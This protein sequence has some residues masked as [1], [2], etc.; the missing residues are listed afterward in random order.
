MIEQCYCAT[1]CPI[2]AAVEE[3]L[4]SYHQIHVE[5]LWGTLAMLQF[6]LYALTST[7][8][9]TGNYFNRN[10]NPDQLSL[11]TESGGHGEQSGP[12][13]RSVADLGRECLLR[14]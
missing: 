11:T 1:G 10:S 8:K 4:L 2:R 6:I 7:R 3:K 13:L 12:R 5:L 9:S 14:F